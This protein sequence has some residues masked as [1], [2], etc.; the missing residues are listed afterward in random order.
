MKSLLIWT[1]PFIIVAHY[2]AVFPH[3][4]THSFVAWA[5]GYKSNPFNI[6]YGGLGLSNLLLLSGIDENVNYEM[7]SQNNPY[8]AAFIAFCGPFMNVILFFVSYWILQHR[9]I[10][11]K[12]YL[13]YWM[14]WFNIMNIAN[15]FDYIPI[16]TF[17]PLNWNT[18]MSNLER[19]LNISPWVVY[20]LGGYFVLFLIW[21]LFSKTLV[22][23][24]VYL[25]LD[26]LWARSFLMIMIVLVL[27]DY[28]SLAGL[29]GFGETS[30]FL[31][32]TSRWI[33]P[34]IIVFC[35]PNRQWVREKVAS[36]RGQLTSNREFV[37]QP[38]LYPET[39][40]APGFQSF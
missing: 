14:L 7:V 16:R 13:Y 19:G 3:E 31:S 9:Q 37:T 15:V 10:Q 32:L 26:S 5:M 40:L 23:A 20:V 38:G 36:I 4:F 8:H 17:T 34:A 11:V 12:P 29:H 18:D 24:Y 39:P 21:Q 35:W 1:L 2:V 30:S 25:G 27:F 22:E 6:T 33:S 28:F